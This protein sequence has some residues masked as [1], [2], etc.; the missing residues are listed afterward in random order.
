M[1]QKVVAVLSD[2]SDYLLE[3]TNCK[4]VRSSIQI[5]LL[6][7]DL[8]QCNA[9]VAMRCVKIMKIRAEWELQKVQRLVDIGPMPIMFSET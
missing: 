2:L 6:S 9:T 8:Y 4:Q 1:K 3:V 5:H 7:S